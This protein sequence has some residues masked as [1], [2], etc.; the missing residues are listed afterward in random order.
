MSKIKEC[1]MAV[2]EIIKENFGIPLT[3]ECVRLSKFDSSESV[4]ILLLLYLLPMPVKKS[5]K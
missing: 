1:I 5:S 4:S 3:A 2:S